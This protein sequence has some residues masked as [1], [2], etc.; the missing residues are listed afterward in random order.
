MAS[1]SRLVKPKSVSRCRDGGRTRSACALPGPALILAHAPC[2]LP[3]QLQIWLSKPEVWPIIAIISGASS[4][5]VYM[6]TRYLT[7]SP[8]LTG[9]SDRAE[10][11]AHRIKNNEAQAITWRA[12]SA[13]NVAKEPGNI[14]VFASYERKSA[15]TVGHALA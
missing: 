1:T 9:I 4:W 12:S 2:R 13:H 10:R 6:G 14:R 5:V 3:A 7:H 8:D 15:A 11:A